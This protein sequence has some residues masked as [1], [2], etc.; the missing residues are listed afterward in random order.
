MKRAA[1]TLVELLIVF[2]VM[3]GLLT[4]GLSLVH[5]VRRSAK[6]TDED[7]H[8]DRGLERLDRD[9]RRDVSAGEQIAAAA[10]HLVIKR[11]GSTITYRYEPPVRFDSM[12][13]GVGHDR[14]AG[15]RSADRSPGSSIIRQFDDGIPTTY[16][17]G[18]RYA[19]AFASGSM[20][21]IRF[22]RRGVSSTPGVGSP[23]RQPAATR[24]TSPAFAIRTFLPAALSDEATEEPPNE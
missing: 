17:V 14:S 22:H 13:A 11:D 24:Q 9:F 20:A 4:G 1:Y 18:H 12:T 2:A 15:G 16:P 6:V 21:E 3:S 7:W 8:F 5:A 10:D 23:G 19:V